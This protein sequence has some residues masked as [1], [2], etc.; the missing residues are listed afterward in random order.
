MNTLTSVTSL[1]SSALLKIRSRSGNLRKRAII[2][3]FFLTNTTHALKFSVSYAFELQ[4]PLQEPID[5]FTR[6]FFIASRFGEAQK[7]QIL[8]PVVDFLIET[9]IVYQ[10]NFFLVLANF[11]R[12]SS[13]SVFTLFN[14]RRLYVVRNF[15]HF[16]LSCFAAQLYQT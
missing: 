4:L 8:S 10:L 11:L 16:K 6:N 13:T 3:C 12:S 7:T 15:L 2:A 9:A 5:S 1:T 14:P